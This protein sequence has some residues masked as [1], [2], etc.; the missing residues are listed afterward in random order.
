MGGGLGGGKRWLLK[1]GMA[2]WYE[3]G[4]ER[5]GGERSEKEKKEKKGGE[6]M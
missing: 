2:L 1:G 5:G 4:Q 6:E 3:S